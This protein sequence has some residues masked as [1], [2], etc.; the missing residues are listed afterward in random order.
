[1]GILRHRYRTRGFM[2]E[3]LF[4]YSAMLAAGLLV[5]FNSEAFVEYVYLA[6]F[7]ILHVSDY[8]KYKET[9][10]SVSYHSYLRR[11]HN[12]FFIRLMTCELCVSV[13]LAI[14]FK[15]VFFL[16]FI[17]IPFIFIYGMMLYFIFK[18]IA[19]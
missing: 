10:C 14:L 4:I 11:Y 19:I 18:R 13:W 17:T 6:G 1:M 12:S 8:V 9:D 3:I 2:I 5:W 15:F 7:N 16:P